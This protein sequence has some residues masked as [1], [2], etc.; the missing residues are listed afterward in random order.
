MATLVVIDIIVMT[1]YSL[2]AHLSKSWLREPKKILWQNRI[3]G[4]ALILIGLVKGLKLIVFHFKIGAISMFL[5][6][7]TNYLI[8]S[9]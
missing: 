6:I 1:S 9:E 3:M 7:I 2:M 5:D 8:C 4:L